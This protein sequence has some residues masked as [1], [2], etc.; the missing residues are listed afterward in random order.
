R[1][2]EGED[3]EQHG[4][5]RVPGRDDGERRPDEDR[6]KYPEENRLGLHRQPL[7]IAFTPALSRERGEPSPIWR[8]DRNVARQLPL[9]ALAVP[10]QPILVVEQLLACLGRK[11]EV[12]PL[13]DGVYRTCL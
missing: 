8:V 2:D 3:E 7:D 4:V 11:F 13:D 6:R 5:D 10:E 1:I 12:R 9:P